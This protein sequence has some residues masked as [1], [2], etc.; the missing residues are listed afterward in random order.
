MED[1]INVQNN[2]EFKNK[3]GWITFFGIAQ[4]IMGIA[5]LLI[6]AFQIVLMFTLFSKQ[7][8]L[9][10]I[11]QYGMFYSIGMYFSLGVINIVLGI[12]A[13]MVK[14]WAR[15]LNLLLSWGWF[16]IFIFC[17]IGMIFVLPTIGNVNPNTPTIAIMIPVILIFLILI[18]IPLI[19]LLFYSGKNVKAT[20]DYFD[21]KVRWTEKVPL[22]VLAVV[23]LF[24]LS[25]ISVL[26]SLFLYPFFPVF[27]YVIVGI[28]AVLIN[29]VIGVLYVYLARGFFHLQ[30]WAWNIATIF[31]TLFAISGGVTFYKLGLI[32]F[33]EKLGMAENF[34]NQIK[35]TNFPNNYL[36]IL[37]FSS[38]FI[39]IGYLLFI[40][41]YFVKV[42]ENLTTR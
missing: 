13:I 25:A 17:F 7:T 39:F 37:T 12:A 21:N 3:K 19:F 23:M 32:G 28:P 41:K 35:N 8:N 9:P 22:P 42:E 18:S 14:K 4:I 11:S 27:G 26:F 31:I 38:A 2:L 6:S 16:I 10:G 34:I 15:D 20:F 36:L 33:Y 30:K 5:V 1:I 24:S 40:K 29:I